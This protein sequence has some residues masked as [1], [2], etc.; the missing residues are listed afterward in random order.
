[1]IFST[2]LVPSSWAGN[3]RPD[4]LA[5]LAGIPCKAVKKHITIAAARA[6]DPVVELSKKLLVLWDADD[7]SQREYIDLKTVPEHVKDDTLHQFGEWRNG[8][9]K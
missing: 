6:A 8:W 2:A 7:G 9:S 3:R 4:L 1:M 5:G